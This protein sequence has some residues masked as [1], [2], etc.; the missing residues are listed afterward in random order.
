MRLR[1]L[2]YSRNQWMFMTTENGLYLLT[3]RYVKEGDLVAVL[4]GGRVPVVLRRVKPS[5]NEGLEELYHL[6]C[7]A[8]IHGIMDG[9]VEEAVHCG[10]V[11]KQDILLV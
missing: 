8:Y 10:W 11:E 2:P 6:V 4:D 1:R 9:D 5:R 3:R 7:V